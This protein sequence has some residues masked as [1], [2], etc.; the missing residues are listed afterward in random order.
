[1][2]GHVCILHILNVGEETPEERGSTLN[3][4]L[5][6]DDDITYVAMMIEARAEYDNPTEKCASTFSNMV[7]C[8]EEVLL[9]IQGDHICAII[10]SLV[11]R[12]SIS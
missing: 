4:T 1:M 8:S 2:Y 11:M 5:I 10:R 9:H 3:Y 12:N 6:S 7:A